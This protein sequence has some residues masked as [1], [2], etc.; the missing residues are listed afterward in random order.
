VAARAPNT[1]TPDFVF[2]VSS[3]VNFPSVMPPGSSQVTTPNGFVYSALAG[4]GVFAVNVAQATATTAASV[5]GLGYFA[6]NS[7]LVNFTSGVQ[8]WK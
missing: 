1:G 4:G 7:L 5:I 6:T 3:G 8:G 2:N